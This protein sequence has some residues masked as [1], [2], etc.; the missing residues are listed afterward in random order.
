MLSGRSASWELGRP[1][2]TQ[3]SQ[4][5]LSNALQFTPGGG[6]VRVSV[7]QVD[8]VVEIRVSDTGRGIGA[9]FLPKV[10]EPFTQEDPSRRRSHRGLGIGLALVRYLVARQAG[11]V[12]ATSVEGKGT[13]I[14]VRFP[15]TSRA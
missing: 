9:E 2:G 3:P 13:T 7:E 11:T 15:A 5:L 14:T 1:Q 6:S 4:T 10:F 12:D 8:K